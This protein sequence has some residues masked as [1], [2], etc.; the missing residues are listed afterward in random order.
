[1]TDEPDLTNG[2]QQIVQM[3]VGEDVAA[4]CGRD[5]LGISGPTPDPKSRSGKRVST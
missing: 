1:M 5:C 2:D 3:A 4:I